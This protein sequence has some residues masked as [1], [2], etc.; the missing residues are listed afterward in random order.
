MKKYL[1]LSL[2]Y[3]NSIGYC[4]SEMIQNIPTQKTTYSPV[5]DIVRYLEKLEKKRN[6]IIS[7]YISN[8]QKIY[9]LGQDS[10]KKAIKAVNEEDFNTAKIEYYNAYS[11]LK[12]SFEFP[13]IKVNDNICSELANIYIMYLTYVID[14]DEYYEVYDYD[15]IKCADE[16]IASFQERFH[17]I[18]E[19][20]IKIKENVEKAKR[21]LEDRYK[22]KNN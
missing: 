9:N 18:E 16:D 19:R 7:P 1:A 6:A 10:Y 13:F 22:L 8:S 15:K 3:F 12:A 11:Y 17:M 4:Q 2:L 21:E 5:K 14:D 20:K